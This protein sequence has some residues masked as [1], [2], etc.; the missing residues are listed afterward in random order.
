MWPSVMGHWMLPKTAA[1]PSLHPEMQQAETE[2]VQSDGSYSGSSVTQCP[3]ADLEERFLVPYLDAKVSPPQLVELAV[4]MEPVTVQAPKV[5]LNGQPKAAKPPRPKPKVATPVFGIG[6]RAS[7]GNFGTLTPRQS[8]RQSPRQTPRQTSDSEDSLK[9]SSRA[10]AGSS[11]SSAAGVIPGTFVSHDHVTSGH[12][13][14]RQR[15]GDPSVAA[16]PN[17]PEQKSLAQR[18]LPLL[19][20]IERRSLIWYCAMWR[21]A[22][23]IQRHQLHAVESSQLLREQ[24]NHLKEMALQRQVNQE[25]LAKVSQALRVS[26]K[27]RHDLHLE[28][29]EAVDAMDAMDATRLPQPEAAEAADVEEMVMEL[30]WLR[31]ELEMAK[32]SEEENSEAECAVL[33]SLRHEMAV[34]RQQDR[35]EFK[36]ELQ[37]ERKSF[38]ELR[39]QSMYR[40]HVSLSPN[41]SIG[42]IS[43]SGAMG[44]P[45]PRRSLRTIVAS[46]S[47]PKSEEAERLLAEEARTAEG[48]CSGLRDEMHIQDIMLRRVRLDEQQL[49]QEEQRLS[50]QLQSAEAAAQQSVAALEERMAQLEAS[51]QRQASADAAES[52]LALQWEESKLRIEAWAFGMAERLHRHHQMKL[53]GACSHAWWLEV[54]R[55]RRVQISVPELGRDE[56]L[57]AAGA[58]AEAL[59]RAEARCEIS[60]LRSQALEAEL[61]AALREQEQEDSYAVTPAWSEGVEE[62]VPSSMPKMDPLQTV[63]LRQLSHWAFDGLF[64]LMRSTFLAWSDQRRRRQCLLKAWS[65]NCTLLSSSLATLCTRAL[66]SVWLQATLASKG[67]LQFQSSRP[68][69]PGILRGANRRTQGALQL[70]E[71]VWLLRFVLTLWSA[72]VLGPNR[73]D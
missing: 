21:D 28:L 4:P 7:F 14:S 35:A 20:R 15:A 49:H 23:I 16:I 6:T 32:I 47:H 30:S 56:H 71:R 45:S 17:P 10:G 46:H 36:H 24:A 8:P 5:R 38:E 33:R 29:D 3:E 48:R 58:A 25:E 61:A 44:A 53:L 13:P 69:R 1:R 62:S 60:R 27:V 40:P 41:T 52:R 18:L 66:F 68:L 43:S 26:E 50:Q 11:A 59:R 57:P 65:S 12:A 9:Q 39:Q 67:R 64:F 63:R 51:E 54:Q 73:Q 31:D 34:Q 72:A 55:S 19:S 2:D 70:L 37:S 22:I 42:E